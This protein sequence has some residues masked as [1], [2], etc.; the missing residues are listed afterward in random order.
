[1][2]KTRRI[3]AICLVIAAVSAVIQIVVFIL[4]PEAI[5]IPVLVCTG[6]IPITLSIALFS[7]KKDDAE[8]K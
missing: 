3:L 4:K 2:S 6:I 5:S 7:S 1:M 8:K